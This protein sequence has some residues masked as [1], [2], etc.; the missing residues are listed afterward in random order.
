VPPPE[1]D[2]S[3]AQVEAIEVSEAASPE[4]ASEPAVAAVEVAEPTD[5]G[6]LN[7]EEAVSRIPEE[8]RKE[9]EKQLRA[10]FRDVRRWKP[11]RS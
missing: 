6:L 8:L 7:L 1:A 5:Q 2:E 10:E 3:L 11:G 9:M 4:T